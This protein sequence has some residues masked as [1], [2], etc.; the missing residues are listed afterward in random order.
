M[1][2]RNKSGADKWKAALVGTNINRIKWEKIVKVKNSEVERI[3]PKRKWKRKGGLGEFVSQKKELRR[4]ALPITSAPI[5]PLSMTYKPNSRPREAKN[6]AK[7]PVIKAVSTP[8]PGPINVANSIGNIADGNKYGN[9]N[10]ISRY[11]YGKVSGGDIEILGN[12]G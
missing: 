11:A 4:S 8:I 2:T 9:G 6:P 1:S 5:V 3:L 12:Y 7:A 10:Q